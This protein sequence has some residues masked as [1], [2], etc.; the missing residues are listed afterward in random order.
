MTSILYN[1]VNYGVTILQLVIF[2]RILLSWFAP[3]TMNDFTD[4]VYS[5]SEP[6][7]KPFRFL[8]PMGNLRMDLSPI[9]AYMALNIIRRALIYFIFRLF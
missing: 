1:I 8:I 5:I 3:N 9:L 4:V 7:L 2:I 6:I